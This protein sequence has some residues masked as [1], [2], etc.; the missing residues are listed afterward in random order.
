MPDSD[1][2][3]RTEQH[4]DDPEHFPRPRINELLSKAVQ[5]PLVIICAGAGYGKTR[6][7][8]DFTKGSGI[9]T[10]WVQ[11][12]ESD[13][14]S[15]RYWENFVHI[16]SHVSEPLA[17]ELKEIG[18]PDTEDK[19]NR[20][21]SARSRYLY[22]DPKTR[23]L[24]VIDDFH[25]TNNPAVINFMERIINDWPKGRSIILICRNPP[26][27]NIL[28]MQANGLVENI[29]EKDLAF[30]EAEL[31][32][33]IRCQGL[34]VNGQTM[35][36]IFQDTN[37]WAFSINLIARSLKKSTNYM[38]Y[39]GNAI[40]HNIFNL[41]ES[42]IWKTISERLKHFLLCLSLIEHLSAE[43]VTKLAGGDESLIAELEQQSAYIRFDSYSGAYLIHHLFKDF[44][45]TKKE[46]LSNDE[47][48]KTYRAAAIWCE[49]NEYIVDALNYY[50]QIKA[51]KEI[52]WIII[53]SPTQVLVG[54]AQR[55]KEIFDR[56]PQEAFDR[57]EL[58]A[59]AHVKVFI[60][61]GLFQ[62][63][64]KTIKSYIDK[65][66][67]LSEEESARNRTIGILYYGWGL[68][69]QVLCTEDDCY[70]FDFYFE[71][72]DRYLS[73]APIPLIR[74][75]HPVG[76]W[77]NLAG[78]GRPGA[79]Q[80]YVAAMD[81]SVLYFKRSY[82]DW[83]AG[84]DVLA[85]GEL[86]FYQGEIA[87]AESSIMQALENARNSGQ[88]EV[89]HRAMFYTMRIAVLQGNYAKFEQTLKKTEMQLKQKGYYDRLFTYDISLGWYYYI[90]R[91]PEKVPNWLKGK[92]TPSF[93]PILLDNFANQMK[94]RYRYLTKDYSPLLT[95]IEDQKEQ[96]QALF[97]RVE[98]LAMEACVRYQMK[99]KAGA[100]R[101]LREAYEMAS[102]NKIVMPF[103]ELG[104]D[105]R[106]LVMAA[107]RDEHCEIPQTWLEL[108]NRKAAYYGKH[109]A[110]IISEYQK[111]N[112]VEAIIALSV[113]ENEVLRDLYNGLTHAEIASKL[114][115][116][117]NTV[118]MI[119]KSIEKKLN[120]HNLADIIRTAVE[121]NLI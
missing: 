61:M 67:K 52:T 24:Y 68:M 65:F 110:L 27:I 117:V 53:E 80:E 116:S 4:L 11:C 87:G 56:A 17:E 108:I 47:R 28:N 37:G 102:P 43:L 23:Y 113:R 14:I 85:R 25:L 95:Y 5:K 76:P 40:R 92:F 29:T 15:S 79:L 111:A 21:L 90:L 7:I 57:V 121:R 41:M 75:N 8:A 3:T 74:N 59:A 82:H 71:K 98:L 62:E 35:D 109:Q 84:E 46:L 69:R 39:V 44:L 30:T 86:L 120:A 9:Q 10:V 81:R 119:Y 66:S 93:H 38:G 45:G 106:A 32:E 19:M 55:L 13:N 112:N 78:S 107:G 99:D 2:K 96:A 42:E 104:K 105:M 94:A 33:Y 70:D 34:S 60:C 26:K 50:E 89:I 36:Q 49:T 100:F 18:F 22:S 103:I 6:A 16:F 83:M 115:L 20:F 31:A 58:F 54:M 91:M 77:I 97:G 1:Q 51:Y 48:N 64:L 72:M 118:K 73:K 114:D 12:S 63:T 88:F 101:S